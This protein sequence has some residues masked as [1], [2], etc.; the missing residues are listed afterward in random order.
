ME[1]RFSE[2]EWREGK[3]KLLEYLR[4]LPDGGKCCV[5]CTCGQHSY[6]KADL[7]RAVEYEMEEG[8]ELIALFLEN[9]FLEPD[10]LPVPEP[11]RSLLG[12][13]WQSIVDFR[14]PPEDLH[15]KP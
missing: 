4:E 10:E 5:S 7:I 12:R 8:R 6:T 13:L 2:Q 15:I 9:E 14:I 1:P 3:E 11:P